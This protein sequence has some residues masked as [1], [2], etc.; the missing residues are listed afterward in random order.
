VK[1]IFQ[2]I[3]GVAGGACIGF[4]NGFFGSG[5]GM[6]CVP[7]MEKALGES[8]RRAHATAILVILPISAVSMVMYL[9]NGY[10]D[11]RLTLFTTVGVVAGGVGGA[12]LLKIMPPKITALAFA[13]SMIGV[14]IKLTFF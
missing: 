6:L 5:G 13:L 12:L 10:W 14:G 1:K 11:A 7:L 2:K 8:T 9:V 4:V 3:I